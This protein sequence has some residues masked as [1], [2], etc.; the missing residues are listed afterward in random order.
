MRI[1]YFDASALVKL[2]VSEA[3]SAWVDAFINARQ[4]GGALSNLVTIVEIGIVEVAAAI[5]RRQRE[6]ALTHQARNQLFRVLSEDKQELFQMIAVTGNI[7]NKAA[8]LTQKYPLRGYDA[9]HLAGALFITQEMANAASASVIFVS[10]DQKLCQAAAA[11]G[12]AVENPANY[13]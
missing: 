5:A 12:L 4:P 2:Y 9:V 10:S 1:S 3:G 11:E 13:L 7:I 6:G 8:A